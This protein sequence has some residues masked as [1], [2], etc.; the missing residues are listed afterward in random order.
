MTL[1]PAPE[2]I[3]IYALVIIGA[4]SYFILRMRYNAV[5][6]EKIGEGY[7]LSK[8][9]HND[10]YLSYRGAVFPI[11]STYEYWVRTGRGFSRLPRWYRFFYLDNGVL[12]EIK[13]LGEVEQAINR[14]LVSQFIRTQTLSQILRSFT[15]PKTMVLLYLAVGVVMGMILGAS[16]TSWFGGV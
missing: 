16:L 6:L 9:R 5:V 7:A 13:E 2:T 1:L 3:I 12:A 15:I 4:V 14:Q 8:A 11:P 10:Y